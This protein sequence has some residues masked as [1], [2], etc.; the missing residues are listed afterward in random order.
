MQGNL[1]KI[2]SS[3]HIVIEKLSSITIGLDGKTIIVVEGKEYK[4]G[5]TPEQVVHF[6]NQATEKPTPV[7]TPSDWAG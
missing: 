4:T 6:Y 3:T 7:V 2:S 1:F 5:L